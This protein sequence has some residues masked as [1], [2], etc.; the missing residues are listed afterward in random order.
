MDNRKPRRSRPSSTVGFFKGWNFES[1][2][3][4]IAALSLILALCI[5]SVAFMVWLFVASD[6]NT[7]AYEET[8]TYWVE[9]GDTLWRIAREYSTDHQDVRRVIDIIESL[10]DCDATIYPGQCLTV[11]VF[12]K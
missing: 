7:Y 3:Q 12:Y 11:P 6:T 4:A 2:G 1:W 10:N 8:T 5:G 9:P